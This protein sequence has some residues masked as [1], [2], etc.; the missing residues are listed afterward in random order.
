MQIVLHDPDHLNLYATGGQTQI[1]IFVTGL[2]KV[3]SAE[4][5]VLDSDLGSTE[6]KKYYF[7]ISQLQN[8]ALTYC[9]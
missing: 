4:I 8:R 6:T 1:P 5:A 7:Y 9:H 2:V 3:D